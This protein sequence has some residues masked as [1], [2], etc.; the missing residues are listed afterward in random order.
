[1][2]KIKVLSEEVA[3][4]IAAGEVIERPVSVVKELVE[5]SID[6]GASKITIQIE[7]GGKR[8]IQITDDGIGMSEDDAMQ[9]FERH[10][11]SK[12]R[13]V[14]D[15]FKISSLG[16]RGEALPSIA[17]VSKL[18][19]ITRDEESQMASKVEFDGGR[20]TDFSK[21]SAN[22]GTTITVRKLF[23]NVPARKKFLKSTPVEYKHILNYLHYQAILYPQIQFRLI[24][25][26]KEKL[27]YPAEEDK[28]KRFQAIFGR[29]FLQKDLIEVKV[30]NQ[31]MKLTGYISGLE[32]DNQGFADYRYLFVNGRFIRDKIVL[33]SI[34]SAYEPFIR[35]LRIFQ[36]GKT[37]PFILFLQVDPSQV[38][39]NVHPAKMEIRFGDPGKVHA[40]V[41][42]A[43]SK[44]LLSYEDNKF[45]ELKNKISNTVDTG[46]TTKIESRIFNK[47]TDKKR[48][49]Q[50]KREFKQ[51]YQPDIF[52]QPTET[53]EKIQERIIPTKKDMF[54]RPEEDVINPWQLH[55]S[56]IFVQV[57]EGLMIID[58]HAAHERIIY[59][60]ILHRIHG[61]PAQTQK[62]LFPIVIDLPPHLSQTVP[63]LISE[64]LEVFQ[65]IGFSIKTF[66]GNSIVIDEIP[67]ELED[68]DG[69]DI[70][71]EIIKQLEDEFAETEDFR[72]SISKSVAC[73]AAIKA[74]KKMGKKEMLAL[75]ND[76]FACEVPYFCPHG[77]PL[78]IKMPLIEFEKR[79][80]RT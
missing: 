23:S 40:F 62:L 73:K 59:E 69:G 47:K 14:T 2:G 53:D 71:I 24:A 28:D 64:N 54:L 63:D 32:E 51:I 12:I 4:R 30:E 17:S 37:P 41:K 33:H 20:L 46:K 29:D 70:F 39:F 72:D 13:T 18:T 8:L 57:E 75:I 48:F 27:N 44:L 66:S 35:K 6:A 76:L 19:L 80:K 42:N 5:N 65:K 31:D 50:V 16:F 67:I 10:A 36:Q 77:R 34:K 7:E 60:K 11:T 74:G 26:G 1:M 9:C 61:A 22:V 21:T 56:Y 49:S 45:K 58:Q 25:N 43:I 68:W 3:N 38:D 15:I 78:I 52:K 79:F 55:Q